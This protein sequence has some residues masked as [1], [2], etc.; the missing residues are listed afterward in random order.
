MGAD[1]H[2]ATE[3]PARD[4]GHARNEHVRHGVHPR[5][6]GL[7]V[8][9]RLP[10]RSRHR[11]ERRRAA[12]EQGHGTRRADGGRR[13]A[14]RS[15]VRRTGGRSG[16]AP[17][18]ARALRLKT[19]R[20]AASRGRLRRCGKQPA[21]CASWGWEQPRPTSRPRA[22][23]RGTNAREPARASAKPPG[24]GPRRQ[25]PASRRPRGPKPDRRLRAGRTARRSP[26]GRRRR[27]R[28]QPHRERRRPAR[29]ART[30]KRRP[31]ARGRPTRG[32]GNGES[33]AS[34]T[35]VATRSARHGR[36]AQSQGKDS[37]RIEQPGCSRYGSGGREAAGWR[38]CRSREACR[39]RERSR[40]GRGA[41]VELVARLN[42][43]RPPS[44]ARRRGWRARTRGRGGLALVPPVTS[45]GRVPAAI[46]G[47]AVR[48]LA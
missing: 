7:R 42:A 22:D 24:Q 30:R 47:S 5:A 40:H 19:R 20:Q 37:E 28:P 9:A 25:R 44:A 34:S 17:A 18:D 21:P 35:A 39:R 8:R 16:T 12:E 45:T 46:Y 4:N 23:T 38:A 33:G 36:R 10:G 43:F 27:P 14:D 1:R 29:S 15:G 13:D 32:T 2:D 11:P 3:A 6:G 41:A 26:S 31:P 48:P